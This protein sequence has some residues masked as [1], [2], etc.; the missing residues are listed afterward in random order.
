ML[1]RMPGRGGLLSRLLLPPLTLTL[2]S[3]PPYGGGLGWGS[4]ASA[5]SLFLRH[6]PLR[7]C[8]SDHNDGA[9]KEPVLT[10]I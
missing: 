1:I 10:D 3:L 6:F 4:K 5:G 8:G 9:A 2:D 7:I